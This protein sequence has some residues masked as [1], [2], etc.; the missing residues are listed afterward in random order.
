MSLESLIL[1]KK[2]YN[3]TLDEIR[4]AKLKLI[5][6]MVLM[7]AIIAIEYY[8]QVEF[9]NDIDTQERFICKST[10]K[11]GFKIT[12]DK[13]DGWILKDNHFI[14]DNN[15]ISTRRCRPAQEQSDE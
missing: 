4:Y 12:I 6:P 1:T 7:T 10:I 5:V 8:Q 11:G 15:I 9:Q 3:D 2:C 14:K 13:K